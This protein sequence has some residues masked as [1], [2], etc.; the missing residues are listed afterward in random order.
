MFPLL[1]ETWVEEIYA[2]MLFKKNNSMN[3][4]KA[5]ELLNLSIWDTSRSA[6]S[7]KIHQGTHIYA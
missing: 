3:M 5:A 4:I 6:E 1:I 7:T 2:S